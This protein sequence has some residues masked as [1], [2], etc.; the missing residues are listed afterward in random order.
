MHAGC[1]MQPVFDMEIKQ[2][3]RLKKDGLL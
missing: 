1:G 3:Y 2:V